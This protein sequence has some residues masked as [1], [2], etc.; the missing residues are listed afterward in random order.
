MKKLLLTTVMLAA[1]MLPAKA[2]TITNLG[3]NPTSGAGAFANT[4]PGTV[5]L[6]AVSPQNGGS[7]LPSLGG[8]FI[9]IYDFILD[10][11][12]TLTIAFAT[13]TYA[14]G[15]P[16]FITNFTGAVLNASNTVVLGPELATGCANIPLCQVFGGSATLA[17]GAYHLAISGNAGVDAGYGGN[18]STFAA[19]PGPIAG[20]GLPG[21]T[22]MF[23][24][25]M[26][27]YRRRKVAHQ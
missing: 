11:P 15:D 21:L 8:A 16:Q 27:W 12:Q 19:V 6:P 1:F 3:T 17:A 24:V 23:G 10:M 9:D 26:A 7:G 2:D 20:A 22:A 25:G 14:G 5:I 13:N 18:I 4:D